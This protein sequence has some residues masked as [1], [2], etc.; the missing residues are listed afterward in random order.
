MSFL[1]VLGSSDLTIK[2]N[3]IYVN[4]ATELLAFTLDTEADTIEITKRV[5]KAF[6]QL[7]PFENKYY[8]ANENEVVV[9]WILK[10][11]DN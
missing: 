1:N 9:D 11:N 5:T 2:R 7:T 3:S 10:D 4:Y 6:P 8:G